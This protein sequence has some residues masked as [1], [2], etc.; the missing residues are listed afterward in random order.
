MCNN[1]TVKEIC[2]KLK[3]NQVSDP[4]ARKY[5]SIKKEYKIYIHKLE[6]MSNQKGTINNL[7]R[8]IEKSI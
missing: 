7:K 8:K 3:V 6:Y 1:N 4:R 2:R 5:L